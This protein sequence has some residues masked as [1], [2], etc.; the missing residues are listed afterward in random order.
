MQQSQ[1]N[2]D[3]NKTTPIK[4]EECDSQYFTE[5]IML[6]KASRIMLATSQD[7]VVPINVIR[8]ADCGHVNKE[9]KP[10]IL[11]E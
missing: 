11:G 1:Q 5:V 2:I 4:C 6:R 7:Q 8:C 10:Q 9:F 3:I